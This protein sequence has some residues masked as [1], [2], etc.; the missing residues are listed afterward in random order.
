[1]Y[2]ISESV[3]W[4]AVGDEVILIDLNNGTT[5]GLNETG[6]MIWSAVTTSS[7]D[8]IAE[9]LADKYGVDREAT[10][11]DVKE[12][13]AEMQRRGFVVGGAN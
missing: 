6:G 10:A 9:S 4:Q 12:F 13:I 5:L 7:L 8:E 1:M 2:K 3:A 11:A